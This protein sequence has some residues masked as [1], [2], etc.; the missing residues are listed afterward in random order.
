MTASR[1]RRSHRPTQTFRCHACHDTCCAEILPQHGSQ[2]GFHDIPEQTL[3][4]RA[5]IDPAKLLLDVNEAAAVL[6]IG[7]TTLYDLVKTNQ[8]ASVLV[9]RLRRFRRG[10]LE[11]YAA[12]LTPATYE[13]GR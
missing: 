7:R 3:S 1:T 11:T 4:I 5:A 12:Q 6:G 8:I 13:D 10:D 2:A 9:G